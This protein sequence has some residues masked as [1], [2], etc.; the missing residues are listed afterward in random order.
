[1]QDTCTEAFLSTKQGNMKKSGFVCLFVFVFRNVTNARE[2]LQILTCARHSWP[3]S[4]K[5]FSMPRLLWH[6][7]S[8]YNGHPRRPPTLTPIAE[9]LAVELSLPV[10][11]SSFCRDWDSNTQ[12][13]ASEA[14]ALAHCATAALTYG[15]QKIQSVGHHPL[16]PSTLIR[17][18]VI[19]IT[20]R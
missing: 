14:N 11:T 5:G 3:L 18:L 8:V 20:K 4:S 17:A 9:R 1:M 16:T 7:A 6:K 15:L 2:G 19:L 13:S 10:F 12:P